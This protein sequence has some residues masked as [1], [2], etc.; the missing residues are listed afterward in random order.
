[1]A[2]KFCRFP[3]TGDFCSGECETDYKELQVIKK[4]GEDI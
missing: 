1:M 2:C 3:S 4:I